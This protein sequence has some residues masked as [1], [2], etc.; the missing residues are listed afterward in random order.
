[1]TGS[2]SISSVNSFSLHSRLRGAYV[3]ESNAF[4]LIYGPD[5][6]RDIAQRVD[7]KHPPMSAKDL[8]ANP[9]ALRDVQVI[10]SGWGA[11][12]FDARLLENLPD[13][14]LVLYGAGSVGGLV[15]D[16]FWARDITICSAWAANAIPVSEFC[17]AQILFS[18]KAG[19]SFERQIHQQ[20]KWPSKRPIIHGAYGSTVGLISLGMIGKRVAQLLQPFDVKIIAWSPFTSPADAAEL[21]IE[22]V[23]SLEELFERSDV[24]SLHTAWK[25]ETENLIRG[26]HF[27]RM[28]PGATFINTSRGAIVSEQEMI[29]VLRQR[30]D[31]WALLDVTWPEPPAAGSPLY[32]LSNVVLTPHIAGSTGT[33]CRRMG[34]W[35]IEELDRYLTGQPLQWRVNAEMAKLMA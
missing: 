33:E 17:L 20:G 11:P 12:L 15:T 14:E 24:V 5:E 1:M 29:E 7:L 28:K 26:Q 22:L 34:R 19:W 32:S 9:Q 21:R 30:P 10:F 4:D 25:K 35:M 31:L 27:A 8:R 18:L 13:L 16:A 6:Q 23:G 2:T 3:L